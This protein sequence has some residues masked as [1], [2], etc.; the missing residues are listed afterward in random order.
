MGNVVRYAVGLP[1]IGE[2]GDP[3]LLVD[4]AMAAEDAGWDGVFFWDHLFY[5]QDGWPVANPTAVTP[6][7]RERS[8]SGSASW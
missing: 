2:F 8:A 7:P 5:R 1:N 6:S 3:R 4:L